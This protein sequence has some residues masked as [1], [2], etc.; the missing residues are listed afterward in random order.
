M[1]KNSSIDIDI[2]IELA[3]V[4]AIIVVLRLQH[5]RQLV[6]Y[7]L[8]A[9]Q[10]SSRAFSGAVGCVGRVGVAQ[11]RHVAVL[12]GALPELPSASCARP[13]RGRGLQRWCVSRAPPMSVRAPTSY[14]RVLLC[15]WCMWR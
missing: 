9:L 3:I 4:I 12:Q 6:R 2:V 15:V 5:E 10:V 11:L 13:L 14:L 1:V 7:P 8:G